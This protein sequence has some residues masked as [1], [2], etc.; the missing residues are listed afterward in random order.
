MYRL[1][2]KNLLTD[3]GWTYGDWS[4][5]MSSADVQMTLADHTAVGQ[6]QR[7]YRLEAAKP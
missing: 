1:D 7:F 5:N 2:H 6:P 3:A 4:T